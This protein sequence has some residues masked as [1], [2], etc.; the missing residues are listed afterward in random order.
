MLTGNKVSGFKCTARD[1]LRGSCLCV[2][3]LGLRSDT[4]GLDPG[5]MPQ[6]VS[7]I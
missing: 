5:V 6:L 3:S 4:F 1:V 7:L 2:H